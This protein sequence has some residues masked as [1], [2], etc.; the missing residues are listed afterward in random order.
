MT[1][2]VTRLG[3]LRTVSLAASLLSLSCALRLAPDRAAERQPAGPAASP[4]R[5]GA[6]EVEIE[7]VAHACFLLRSPGGKRVLI[8]P[9]ASRVWLGYDFPRGIEADAVLITHPHY[10]HDGGRRRGGDVSWMSALTV[11][12]GPGVYDLGDLRIT[13]IEGK[14]AE[15]WGKEFGQKNTLWVVEVGGL[16][17]AHLGDNGPLTPENVAALGRVDV[18]MAPIDEGEHILRWADLAAIR[19]ALQP[20]ILIP[21]HYRIAELERDPESPRDLGSIEPWIAR[22]PR[23]RRLGTHR[24]VFRAGSLPERPEVVVFSFSPAVTAARTPQP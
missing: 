23:V 21:M 4:D 8:D 24:A 6:G 14:H 9:Y 16:R 15:P 17:I 10:D 2:S 3:L 1:R 5:L 12:D 22:E 13:G 18:L 11:W 19:S 20:S 7:Y